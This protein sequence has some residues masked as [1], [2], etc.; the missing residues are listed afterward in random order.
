MRLL[1]EEDAQQKAH[2]AAVGDPLRREPLELRLR[3]RRVQPVGQ[4]RRTSKARF[5]RGQKIGLA[6]AAH[7]DQLRGEVA[8]PGQLLEL[9]ERVIGVQRPQPLGIEYAGLRR[10][11]ERAQV[12]E[13]AR[14]E[15]AK[16][17]E[18]AQPGGGWEGKALVAVD[19]DRVS[20][21]TGDPFVLIEDYQD[22]YKAL[23]G[24]S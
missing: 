12:V 4:R 24:V 9:G 1:L 11:G 15:A 5:V 16:G 21:L 23:W 19:V 10:I 18:L 7:Q 3:G 6:G 8:D 14:A 13:L 20:Q 2:P 17:P 22:Q